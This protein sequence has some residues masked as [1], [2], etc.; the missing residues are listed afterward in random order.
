MEVCKTFDVSLSII[1]IFV[2]TP[3]EQ[4]KLWRYLHAFVIVTA[5]NF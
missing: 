3:A 2:V 1:H 5:C 4:N